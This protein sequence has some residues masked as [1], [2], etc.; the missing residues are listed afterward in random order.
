M[1]DDDSPPARGE[2]LD[3]TQQRWL[4]E[5]LAAGRA[6]VAKYARGP[7]KGELPS[8]AALEKA[9]DGWRAAPA[10][11]REPVRDAVE[12]LGALLGAHLVA[13]DGL[14]WIVVKDDE[15]SD[16]AVYGAA[17]ELLVYPIMYVRTHNEAD[18]PLAAEAM[19]QDVSRRWRDLNEALSGDL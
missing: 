16:L 12:A 9:Y 1:S 2:G 14:A 17:A 19:V 7:G 18:E 8:L 10:G 5:R 11:E 4:A 13:L 15:S 6:L 3:E